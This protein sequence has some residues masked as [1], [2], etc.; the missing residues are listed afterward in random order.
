MLEDQLSN[1]GKLKEVLADKEE[2]ISQLQE[3]KQKY[4]DFYDDKL[5]QEYE[6]T[7]RQKTK[8]DEQGARA[9]ELEDE[10]ENLRQEAND[11]AEQLTTLRDQVKDKDNVL[12]FVELE[13]TKIKEKQDMER[14]EMD[15][16]DDLIAELRHS[17]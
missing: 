4:R 5:S 8:T 6:E 13:V 14:Q 3:S 11:L 9:Q 2:E 7:E 10:N 15:A 17:N 1:I 16:K 12:E